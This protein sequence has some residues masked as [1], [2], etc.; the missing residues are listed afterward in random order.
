MKAGNNSTQWCV[1]TYQQ[2]YDAENVETGKDSWQA[3]GGWSNET[4]THA[5][6]AVKARYGAQSDK[7]PP[8]RQDSKRE[9]NRGHVQTLAVVERGIRGA[10]DEAEVD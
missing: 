2:V 1:S 9:T 5:I 7:T 4:M 8:E 6:D 10:D 3:L